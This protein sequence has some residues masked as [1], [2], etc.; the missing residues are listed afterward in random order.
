LPLLSVALGATA[1]V[2]AYTIPGTLLSTRRSALA[3]ALVVALFASLRQS[4]LLGD[5][6]RLVRA[7]RELRLSQTKYR[8]TLDLIPLPVQITSH[9]EGR[10]VEL[11]RA[12]TETFGFVLAE[13]LGRGLWANL[14]DRNRFVNQLSATGHVTAFEAVWRGKDGK[15]RPSILTAAITTLEGEPHCVFVIQDIEE[16]MR[17]EQALRA[18]EERTQL[19]LATTLDAVVNMDRSGRVTEWNA[20]AER[21]FGRTREQALG[22]MLSE[23]IVPPAQRAEHAAGFARYL[24]TGESRILGKRLEMSALRADG[25]EFPVELSVSAVRSGPELFFSAFLRD[26]TASKRAEEERR[27]LETQLRQSQKM[28]AVGTLAAGI[29]HDFNNLLSAIRGNT[30]LAAM[31]LPPEHPALESI[32]EIERASKR[33]TDLVQQIVSFSRPRPRAVERVNLREVVA[34]VVRLLRSTLP[35]GVELKSTSEGG[36]PAVM[37]DATQVHQ[38]LVNLCT[39]A[40]QAMESRPGKI[41]IRIERATLSRDAPLELAP[42][43][44]ACIAVEDTGR[45]MTEDTK[46]RIFEPFF[47]TRP[48]G[49]GTGLGL[50]MAHS[51]VRGHQGT[52]TVE[53]T[54]DVGTTFRVYLPAAPGEAD[55]ERPR[56]Q[57]R[58]RG[59]GG[60]KVVYVDDEDPLVFLVT[61]QLRRRGYDVTG[62]GSAEAALTAIDEGGT[63]FDVLVTDY[64]MP[65][66]SG[67]DLIR[68]VK[69]VRKD[70]RF[71]LT[72][73]FISD[74]MRTQAAELEVEHLIYKPN[75]VDELCEAIDRVTLEL[76]QPPPRAPAP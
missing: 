51:I 5:R 20:E 58:A 61:R 1:V 16:R 64:N 17:A 4:L 56:E 14:E 65:R 9:P 69:A 45:G 6:E 73:G 26:L 36:A 13:S 54:L 53:T 39:N 3:G 8:A 38:V 19:V 63:P 27:E 41:E 66:M 23:L 57:A 44:Y 40:W 32:E 22:A 68:A 2:L 46:A 31:D 7:E 76:F 48:R 55:A 21:I 11:N 59:N 74:E 60:R 72:S 67:I 29:A 70:A 28:E 12:F 34:E 15:E 43:D 47:S 71:V 25:S 49:R 35:A 24:A 37:A 18:S 75:N 33:A 30:E 42:G 50:S 52:I 10:L 62:Y